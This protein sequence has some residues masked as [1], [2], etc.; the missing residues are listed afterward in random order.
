MIKT[1]KH[2][3]LERFFTT[4]KTTGIRPDQADKI[5]ARLKAI[6][7]A[8]T[9]EDLQ[10]PGY[11]LHP[12]KGDR[13]GVWSITVSGNWRIVFEFTDGNAYIVNYEDYH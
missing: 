4:G 12:L 5:R 2:K 7:S 6:H 10:L 3:G 8:L 11:K 13:A 9:I 1:F